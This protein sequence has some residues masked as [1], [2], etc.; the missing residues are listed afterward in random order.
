MKEL[1]IREGDLV[2]SD[3]GFDT[4]GSTL[5]R[6]NRRA[7]RSVV[8]D[9]SNQVALLYVQKHN[10]H[11]LPGGGIEDGE[12]EKKALTRDIRE[13]VGTEVSIGNKIGKV[14]EYRDQYGQI[15]TSTAYVSHI[16]GDKTTQQFTELEQ[17]QG[18]S[19]DW[20]PL[21][22]AL[23]II[24][25]ETPTNYEGRFIQRRDSAILSWVKDSLEI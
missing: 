13:E 14:I 4:H 22:R 7:V 19:L 15:Q 17:L 12:D 3:I 6:R 18:F 16:H 5:D 1:E 23:Q 25:G 24:Q 11:K 2:L 9:N 21:D 20:V 8:L 10:Y